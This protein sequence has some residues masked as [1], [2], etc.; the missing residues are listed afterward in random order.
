M[1]RTF[2]IVTVLLATMAPAWADEP[3]AEPVLRVTV[4]WR[5]EALA[6]DSFADSSAQV[7]A[8]DESAADAG[9]S[10]SWSTFALTVEAGA[11][12]GDVIGWTVAGRLGFASLQLEEEV[13]AN[14]ALWSGGG[15]RRV[16]ATGANDGVTG[17]VSAGARYPVGASTW[18]T[19][20]EYR[21]DFGYAAL[22]NATL[23]GGTPIQGTAR[24]RR[25][26]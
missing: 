3:G 10:F 9:A 8:R 6:V 4:A 19:G 12:G 16:A 25:R 7:S 2:C 22:D 11:G 5:R 1:V 20:A 17:G 14:A 24:A 21:L 13:Q 26:S 18:W 23:F 15:P